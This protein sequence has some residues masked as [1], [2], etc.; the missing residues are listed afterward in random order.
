MATFYT[1]LLQSD[2]LIHQLDMSS[3]ESACFFVSFPTCAPFPTAKGVA[4]VVLSAVRTEVRGLLPAG[5]AVNPHLAT[6]WQTGSGGR[7]GKSPVASA[8]RLEV[9]W[10]RRC[11]ASHSLRVWLCNNALS[12]RFVSQA[13]A[14][15]SAGV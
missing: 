10:R 5:P 2:R 13:P 6:D 11:R 14:S 7:G 1:V 3:I 4:S 15:T 8:A 12:W 9:F